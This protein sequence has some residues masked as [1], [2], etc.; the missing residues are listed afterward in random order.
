M[1][2]PYIGEIRL[3]GFNRIPSGW[4]ACDGTLL[5]I[6]QYDALYTLLG[7]TFGGDGQST[8]GVPDLRG[9]LPI[10]QGQGPGLSNYVMGQMAGTENVTLTTAQMPQHTH[11][12][13]ASTNVGAEMS[14][15]GNVIGSTADQ[16]LYVPNTS[17]Q[18]SSPLN[19][20][21]LMPAGGGQPHENCMPTLVV[22]YCIA[23]NGIWPSQ[24]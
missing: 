13:M 18:V 20:G 21:A 9:R 19:G 11:S 10:H 15:N 16:E 24:N 1:S 14:P 7:T 4:Q 22:N 17:G 8:F 23:T 12:L 5:A 6:S 2:E 3:F